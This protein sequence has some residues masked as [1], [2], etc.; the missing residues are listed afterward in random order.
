MW[1]ASRG[2]WWVW[3]GYRRALPEGFHSCSFPIQNRDTHDAGETHHTLYRII[4]YQY[5]YPQQTD[6]G[7]LGLYT[8][9]SSM[10]VLAL[11]S[12]SNSATIR[13]RTSYCFL[14]CHEATSQHYTW[15]QQYSRWRN[16][17]A[18]VKLKKQNHMNLFLH[19]EKINNIW[20]IQSGGSESDDAAVSGYGDG[21]GSHLVWRIYL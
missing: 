2:G 6:F 21:W 5:T 8:C 20:N 11:F 4:A 1:S 12:P 9:K 19:Y 3:K 7:L 18:T 15:T 10:T 17:A 14:S 13:C 16:S